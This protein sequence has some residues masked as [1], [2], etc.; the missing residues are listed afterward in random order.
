[1]YNFNHSQ[2]NRCPTARRAN[3]NAKHPFVFQRAAR[4]AAAAANVYFTD[5]DATAIMIVVIGATKRVAHRR[6]PAV[7][8]RSLSAAMGFVYR[9]SGIAIGSRTAIAV[10]TR[11]IANEADWGWLRHGLARRMSLGVRMDDVLL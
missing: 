8:R 1:M 4:A 9:H 10:K 6:C 5:F 11:R 3:S 2:N 7:R